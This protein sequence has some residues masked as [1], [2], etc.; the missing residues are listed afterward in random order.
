MEISFEG[1][2][3]LVTG[4][5]GG[6][7]L[8]T[9]VAFAESGANVVLADI[10]AA[11]AEEQAA[12]LRA[13][14]LSAMAVGCDVSDEAQVRDM[15][16]RTVEAFGS[17]DAAFNNAGV[18]SPSVDITE[19][20]SAEF[21]RVIGVDLKGVWLCMKYELTQMRR[22]GSGAI[23]N[24]SSN[25]GLVG[26]GG[27]SPYCAAK[28]GV[29]GMTKSV[30]IDYAPMGIRINAVCPGTIMTPMVQ[31]MVDSGDLSLDVCAALAPANRLGTGKEIA[32][33]VLWL[34]SDASSYVTGQSIAVDGGYTII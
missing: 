15:V 6:M 14:G 5:A 34:C 2:T 21:D 22:Q 4:A 18:N 10:S 20:D 33:A 9:A 24:C 12:A 7:G 8:D 30:A 32:D 19:I 16:A 3:A 28:H 1:K 11:K 26:T 17:L 29:L 31:Q 27:R 13:R 25:S 23:V